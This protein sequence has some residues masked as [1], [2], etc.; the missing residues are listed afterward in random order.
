MEIISGASQNFFVLI[1]SFAFALFAATRA[2]E[3]V[4][5]FIGKGEDSRHFDSMS[6]FSLVVTSAGIMPLLLSDYKYVIEASSYIYFT[7]AFGVI[8]GVFQDIYYKQITFK[9]KIISYFLIFL[10]LLTLIALLLNAFVFSSI[11]VYR[12]SVFI[13]FIVLCFRYYLIFA[14]M[15][16]QAQKN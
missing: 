7:T 16:T 5:E 2:I 1:A 8:I 15:A 14:D 10:S 12:L 9:Y 4:R 11:L 6:T 13:G 3:S